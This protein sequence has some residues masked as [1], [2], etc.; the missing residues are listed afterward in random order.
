MI[1]VDASVALAW[2]LPDSEARHRYAAS[3]TE[4]A[5]ELV[6]PRVLVHECSYRLL[7]FGRDKRWTTVKIAE[8]AE[9]IDLFRIRYFDTAGQLAELVRFALRHNVTGYDAVYL[10]L[11]M[12][13]GAKLAT[14]DNGLRVNAGRAGVVPFA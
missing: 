12:S 14:L 4:A 11:A 2:V 1:V 13:L 10:A 7:K 8:Y 6:A 5:D 3:V 9:V